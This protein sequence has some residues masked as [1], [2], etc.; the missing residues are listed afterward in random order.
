MNKVWLI[1]SNTYRSRVH[2]GSFLLLTFAVPVLM[3]V[4]GAISVIFFGDNV[5][6]KS[7]GYVDLTG[8]LSEV[9]RVE[10]GGALKLIR[11][12][13]VEQAQTAFQEGQ[14]Q[15]YLVIPEGYFEGERVIFYAEEAPGAELRAALERFM[16]RALLPAAPE[17][18]LE[19]MADPAHITYVSL[20]NGAEV[21]S[22]LG[23]AIFFITPAI[24]ALV[25][26]IAVAF[27]TGQ[28]GS[29][30][31]RE[32]EQ[33]A[34]EMVITSLRPSQLVAGKVLGLSLLVLTQFGI[35]IVGTI[36]ALVLFAPGGIGLQGVVLPWGAILWGILLIVPGYL[37]F[38]ILGAGAGIIAGD[39]QQAQQ[40]A[41]M[42]GVL[43][44]V[45][46]WLTPVWI[47]QP[48]G[49]AAIALTLFPLTGPT[50]ALLRM[51]F[52]QVPAWQLGASFALLVLSLLLATLLVAR[53]FR[54]AMLV[55]GQPLR[56][57]QLWQALRQ[58]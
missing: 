50:I 52:S 26:A 44:F 36:L 7:V 35:W 15:S 8:R 18:V 14:I 12:E 33:R 30:V 58:A 54:A 5:D 27:T 45:P 23:L 17:I 13:H 24:L 46:L 37:L 55:Y 20:E 4:A 57:R 21:S 16:R 42:L 11:L 38:A 6:L 34:M 31:V 28:M 3:F 53:I 22:G 10:N 19:R 43:G 47:N 32:K 49:G 40:L 48:A 56:P 25:Y 29:A 1:A 51:A 2:T 9:T 41:G 39:N